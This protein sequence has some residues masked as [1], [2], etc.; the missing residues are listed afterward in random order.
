MNKCSTETRMT[1]KQRMT[2]KKLMATELGECAG[3][4]VKY[5]LPDLPTTACVVVICRVLDSDNSHTLANQ[6]EASNTAVRH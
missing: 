4:M 1:R 5:I 3:K 6:L 2:G